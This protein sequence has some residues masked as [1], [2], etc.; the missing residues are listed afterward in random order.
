ML[1]EAWN[2][3]STGCGSPLLFPLSTR[4][5][6]S[7]SLEGRRESSTRNGGRGES[8]IQGQ[9]AGRGV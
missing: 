3:P 7:S 4:Y 8:G 5:S 2:P 1:P 9:L 6:L